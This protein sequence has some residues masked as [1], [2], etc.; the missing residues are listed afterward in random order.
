MAFTQCEICGVNDWALIHEGRIRRGGATDFIDGGRVG[1]CRGCGVTRLDEASSVSSS[2][3]ENTDYRALM[4]QGIE[5][6]DFFENHDA[7]QIHN[8]RGLWPQ[9]LRGKTVADIGCGAGSYLDFVS[10]VAAQSIAVEPTEKFHKSLSE[11]GYDV[12]SYT[13]DLAESAPHSVD[14]VSSFQVIEHVENPVLFLKDIKSILKPDG[15]LLIATPNLDDILMTVLP[16]HFPQFYYRMVHRWYFTME[17]LLKAAEL[18]G[19]RA[20]TKRYIHTFGM[21]NALVWLR[22]KAPKGDTRL[23]GITDQADALWRTYLESSGQAD[24]IYVTFRPA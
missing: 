24:T 9:S 17:T 15:A 8:L 5:P 4:D 23:N 14:F 22:D 18:A 20:E 12:Y 1:R 2:A 6:E 11:R 10:G 7:T 3:Y 21:A 19:F 16:D 13:R